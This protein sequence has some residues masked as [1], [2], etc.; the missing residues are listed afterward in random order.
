[1]RERVRHFSRRFVVE[2]NAV[3]YKSLRDSPTGD[4]TFNPQEQQAGPCSMKP[5][6]HDEAVKGSCVGNCSS[7][8]NALIDPP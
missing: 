1:M 3:R 2:S 5:N 8:A 7:I 4:T 6:A